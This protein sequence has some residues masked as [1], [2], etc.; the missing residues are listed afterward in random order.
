MVPGAKIVVRNLGTAEQRTAESD[1]AGEYVVP[2]LPIGTYRVDVT[3]QGMQSVV[4][5]I[6]HGREA[7]FSRALDTWTMPI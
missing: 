5:N 4:V 6:R 7:A 2:S 1:S 3:A